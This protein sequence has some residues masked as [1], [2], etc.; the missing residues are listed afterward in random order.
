MMKS[1]TSFAI[2]LYLVSTCIAGGKDE[3]GSVI[4]INNHS[5]GGSGEGVGH[6]GSGGGEATTIVKMNPK[7]GNT[8]IVKGAS[9]KKK[10][11]EHEQVH[12]PVPVPVPV[13]I[14]HHQQHTGHGHMSHDASHNILSYA[15]RH[16]SHPHPLMAR[17]NV[18]S[19]DRSVNSDR[20]SSIDFP[21]FVKEATSSSHHEPS[22]SGS[23]TH[24]VFVKDVSASE[25]LTAESSA[26]LSLALPPVGAS[27]PSAP[28][29][30][31]HLP[32]YTKA[33]K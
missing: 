9:S 17:H 2:L 28:V 32:V 20:R 13:H 24:P 25:P 11:Q 8:I 10:K 22:T 1:V 19:N 15:M 4:V 33:K 12:V 26:P 30:Q 29:A 18:A 14:P 16:S 7:K 23:S 6:C 5:G 31:V 21:V 27:G 3:K